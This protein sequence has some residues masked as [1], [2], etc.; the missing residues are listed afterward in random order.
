MKQGLLIFSILM[1]LSSLAYAS[2]PYKIQAQINE[3]DKA[4]AVGTNSL[5]ITIIPSEP[6]VLKMKTPLKLSLQGSDGVKFVKQTL[7]K[8]DVVDPESTNKSLKTTFN[9]E[10]SGEHKISTDASFFLCTP[11]VCKRFTEKVETDFNV[12]QK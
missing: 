9:V 1:G 8:A 6:W 4:P 2:V 11:E 10:K 3:A 5:S 7:G 12:A